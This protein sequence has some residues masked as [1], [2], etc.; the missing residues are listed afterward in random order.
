MRVLERAAALASDN[1]PL[2]AFLGAHFFS[3]GRTALARDY[4]T[5]AFDADP[6]NWR[7]RLLLGLVCGD[8][9]EPERARKLLGEAVKRGGPSFAAHCALGRLAAAEDDWKTALAEFKR[10]LAARPC[11]EAHYLVGLVYYQLARDR[12]AL[13][14][15]MKAVELDATYGA[16]LYLLG[17]VQLRLGER[18]RAAEAFDAARA[19]DADEPRYAAARKNPARVA[20]AQPPS[21]FEGKGR[22]SRR[23][24]TGGDDRLAAVLQDDALGTPTPR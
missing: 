22:G 9:G 14:H 13:R 15:L 11:P 12:S 5:R 8:E 23:V 6:D 4:L 17:L 1:A 7:V 3:K 18:R 10:A 19:S 24:V 21:L 20:G 16:A 2:N